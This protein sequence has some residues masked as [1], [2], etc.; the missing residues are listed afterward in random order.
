MWN[1]RDARN[2]LPGTSLRIENELDVRFVRSTGCSFAA[3]T[4]SSTTG[5]SALCRISS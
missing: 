5:A 2:A 4:V 3:S 1:P